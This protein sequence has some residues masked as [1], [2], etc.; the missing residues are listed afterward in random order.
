MQVICLKHV[1]GYEKGEAPKKDTNNSEG[2]DEFAKQLLSRGDEEPTDFYK[3]AI[4][5]TMIIT[6]KGV[7]PPLSWCCGFGAFT[8]AIREWRFLALSFKVYQLIS[9]IRKD[10]ARLSLFWVKAVLEGF[11]RF[12]ELEKQIHL[13]RVM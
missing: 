12:W 13:F 3:A 2:M 6:M 1:R 9:L 10:F 8:S 5:D 7:R 11:L 4:E